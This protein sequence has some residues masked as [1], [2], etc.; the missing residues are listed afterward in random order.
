MCI[1]CLALMTKFNVIFMVLKCKLGSYKEKG[2]HVLCCLV[3]VIPNSS[4]R[5]HVEL[6]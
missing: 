6:D 1:V 5:F 4:Q 3:F 2:V